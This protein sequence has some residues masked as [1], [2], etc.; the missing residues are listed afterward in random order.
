MKKKAFFLLFCLAFILRFYKINSPII[1]MHSWRQ[2]DTAAISRN[3]Y[4]NGYRFLYP[5]I[6]WGGDSQGYVETE[7]PIYSFIVAL[8]YGVFGVHEFLGRLLSVIF[9]MISLYYLYFLLLKMSDRKTALWSC[10][11]F[12]ILPPLIFYSRTFQPESTLVM[13]LILGVYFFSQ[14]MDTEKIIYFITSL[15]F[16]AL[17]CLIKIPSLYI[18]LPILYLA[19]MKSGKKIFYQISMWIYGLIVLLSVA[20]WYYHA[21]RIHLKTGLTFGI[22]EYGLDKWGN[23]DLIFQWKFWN[24]IIFQNLA[25]DY[26]VW[27]GFII[28]VIGMFL[29]RKSKLETLSDVWLMALV[30]YFIIVARGNYIHLYYQLPFMIPAVIYLGKVYAQHFHPKDLK[31]KKTI[32]LSAGLI[33]ICLLTA[34]RYTIYIEKENTRNSDLYKLAE[35]VKD[36]IEDKALVIAIDNNDPTLLYLAHKKGWHAFPNQ[37]DTSFVTQKN[38]KGARYIIGNHNLFKG[39]LELS[40]LRE[41]LKNH[42]VIY[43]DKSSFILEISEEMR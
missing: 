2:A 4:E 40:R 10:F 3:Y 31:N 24:R 16:I 22:W 41:L 30:I 1:G 25:E 9:A 33:G 11:F 18:G 42:K 37:L 23:W 17:A 29:K 26:F 20:L 32:L 43:D 36:K 39:D 27:I 19:W 35:I 38:N 7:F 12:A 14:W 5:Q 34:G 21:H 15:I 13:S 6:D 8:L 28:F